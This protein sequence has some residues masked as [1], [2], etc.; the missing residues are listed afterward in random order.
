ME[1]EKQLKM[2]EKRKLETNAV[3]NKPLTKKSKNSGGNKRKKARSKAVNRKAGDDTVNNTPPIKPNKNS[4]GSKRKKTRS[5]KANGKSCKSCGA[6]THKTKR[7]KKCPYHK[8]NLEDPDVLTIALAEKSKQQH[9]L[10]REKQDSGSE[11]VEWDYD[12]SDDNDYVPPTK[13]TA[14]AAKSTTTTAAKST[15]TTAA[16]ST[17]T[18]AA[19][20]TT[21]TAAAKSTTATAAKST[22]NTTAVTTT[23]TTAKSTATTVAATKSTST[24]TDAM[25]HPGMT[26]NARWSDGKYYGAQIMCRL[27]DGTYK[28]YYTDDGEVLQH[29]QLEHIRMPLMQ[30][31]M[32][33]DLTVGRVFYDD[34]K[35]DGVNMFTPGKWKVDRVNHKNVAEFVCKRL[36][37]GV[38][39]VGEF[40][41]FDVGHVMR[42]V[43][44]TEKRDKGIL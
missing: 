9:D 25:L 43:V 35:V 31:A 8:E 38:E 20:S 13:S 10:G 44:K 23:T 16:K 41:E 36:T 2:A 11:T 18:A 1:K 7:S 6:F 3:N 30:P 29:V 32:T 12:N 33:R 19:K 26:V 15:T 24:V 42:E 22:T 21:T 5:R 40:Q 4:G 39:E 14:A 37:G 17:T 28:V 27:R 34:G